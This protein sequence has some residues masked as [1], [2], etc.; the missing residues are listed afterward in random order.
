MGSVAAQRNVID[1]SKASGFTLIEF[2]VVTMLVAAIA[3]IAL[4]RAFQPVETSTPVQADRLAR[5]I[6]HTQ[7]LAMQWGAPL[8]L[9]STA[10]GYSVACVSGSATAPCN[11]ASPVV[12][13]ADIARP[14]G[15]VVTLENGVTLNATSVSVDSLGR[16]CAS[17]CTTLANVQTTTTTFSLTGG[18]RTSTVTVRPLT[19][20]IGVTY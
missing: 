18:G 14:G 11:G 13:P 20:S 12:D 17:P 6:R 5:D 9:T 7:M 15:Y 8:R 4:L 16:P 1:S 2:V 3:A 10:S 19:G